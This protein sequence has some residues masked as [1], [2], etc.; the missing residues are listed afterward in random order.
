MA[1]H[2]H[3]VVIGCFS[4]RNCEHVCSSE[5]W[6]VVART[7]VPWHDIRY[8]GYGKDKVSYVESVAAFQFKFMV[9]HDAFAIHR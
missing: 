4:L 5:P 8:R 6:F 1:F 9:L 2:L 3:V 7:L